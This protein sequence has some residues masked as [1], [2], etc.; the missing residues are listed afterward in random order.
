MAGTKKKTEVKDEQQELTLDVRIT[1]LTAQITQTEGV[2][3]QMRGALA[4]CKE[5]KALEKKE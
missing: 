2:L 1:N 3:N 5:L 4:I